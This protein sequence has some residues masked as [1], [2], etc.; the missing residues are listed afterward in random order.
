M[1]P[2]IP[3]RSVKPARVRSYAHEQGWTTRRGDDCCAEHEF[4]AIAQ[5]G[6]AEQGEDGLAHLPVMRREKEGKGHEAAL[7]AT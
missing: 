5:A 3:A 1:M 7:G 4:G 6:K 2:D